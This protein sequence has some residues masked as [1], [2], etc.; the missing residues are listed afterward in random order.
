[1]CNDYS[2]T[3]IVAFNQSLI[4]VLLSGV[5]QDVEETTV[6]R[7]IDFTSIAASNTANDDD[8]N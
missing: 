8:T 4:D 5:F 7:C 6:D 1:V 3:F 2:Q